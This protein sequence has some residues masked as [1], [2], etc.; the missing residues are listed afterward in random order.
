MTIKE[1]EIFNGTNGALWLT[2]ETEE[3]EIMSIQSFSMT[4]TNEYEEFNKPGEYG[5]YQ[6][7]LGYSLQGTISKY[8]TDNSFI[9]I[10]KKYS[11][12]NQPDLSIIAKVENPNT[13]KLQRIKYKRSYYINNN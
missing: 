2:G 8:K 7:F 5:K 9:N 10:M 1:N 11:E 6:K 3:I 4:Q 13:G 12:G